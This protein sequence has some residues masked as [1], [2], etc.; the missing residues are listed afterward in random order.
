MNIDKID[1]GRLLTDKRYVRS[2]QES[3]DNPYYPLV[4]A[5][6]KKMMD[7]ANDSSIESFEIDDSSNRLKITIFKAIDQKNQGGLFE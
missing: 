6:F 5:A 3:W 2:V 7:L 4:G 1:I